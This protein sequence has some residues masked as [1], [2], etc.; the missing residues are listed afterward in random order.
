MVFVDV[1][2]EGKKDTITLFV[3]FENKV[4]PVK[5]PETGAA[6]NKDAS[7]PDTVAIKK[8]QVKSKPVDSVGLKKTTTKAKSDSAAANRVTAKSLPV[9]A[10]QP[11]CRD[12]AS[13]ADIL[14]LRSA[15]L[16][17]NIDQEKIAV[18]SGGFALKCFSVSQIRQLASLLVADKSRY[19]LMEA[20][21]GHIAD[22]EH[23]PELADMYTDKNF[24]R[25][26]LV[27]AEKGS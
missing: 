8:S 26:F 11:V 22:P 4:V 17:A 25:K 3:Y 18:A 16:K 20:A 6:V 1:N 19:R 13:D 7:G 23:F 15:I 24:Q 2:S 27:M 14:Y 5:V 9:K 10:G 21:R 12:L